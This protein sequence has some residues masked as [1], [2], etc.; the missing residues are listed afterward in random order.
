MALKANCD[1]AIV[2]PS[3]EKDRMMIQL[4]P[5]NEESSGHG[6]DNLYRALNQ[7][8]VEKAEASV[9]RDRIVI[10][11][12]IR[13][14]RGFREVNLLV[15][16]RLRAWIRGVLDELVEDRSLDARISADGDEDNVMAD[17]ER[18]SYAD[19]LKKVADVFDLYGD[20]AGASDMY[21][22]CLRIR[23]SARE[24]NDVKVAEAYDDCGRALSSQGSYAS[25]L[26]SYLKALR[27]REKVLG[28]DDLQTAATNFHIGVLLQ[29]MGDTEE[30][31]IMLQKCALVQ[32]S[33]LGKT[34]R[35]TAL[36]YSHIG[37]L[38]GKRDGGGSYYKGLEITHETLQL[39]KDL[40][41]EHHPKTGFCYGVLATLLLESD[42][43]GAL[44][45]AE[46][47][48]TIQEEALGRKHPSLGKTYDL[49]GTILKRQ[50]KP[51]KAL[52][53]FQ[54]AL[55]IHEANAQ[56]AD[57]HLAVAMTSANMSVLS[58]FLGDR[59]EAKR[60]HRRVLRALGD[61]N[62]FD[63]LDQDLILV[64]STS[65]EMFYEKGNHE[66][67]IFL[68]RQGLDL[69]EAMLGKDHPDLAEGHEAVGVALYE[70]GD[71]RGALQEYE[72]SLTIRNTDV[73]QRDTPKVLETTRL[74]AGI[75][76]Q[77]LERRSGE[78]MQTR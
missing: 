59:A 1:V 70:K 37:L 45:N 46:K 14:E 33:K 69:M 6:I 68:F 73:T 22:Q 71:Y 65:G 11:E 47:C 58:F 40:L 60:F 42:L 49:L 2:M 32:E 20:Y 17:A 76:T 9:A 77:W 75:T 50:M 44:I 12:Q 61:S 27:I 72:R 43:D 67:A 23:Q 13:E 66:A 19:F 16:D 10:L 52:C 18:L 21:S 28:K 26:D 41:G 15:Q 62:G 29:Q 57:D 51:Q 54:Q 48:C 55:E 24:L 8:D 35:D 7:V 63:V 74:I 25:S 38:L 56:N 78:E 64:Y 3:L 31:L 5:P 53:R 34:H 4:F 30:A 39:F 36:T